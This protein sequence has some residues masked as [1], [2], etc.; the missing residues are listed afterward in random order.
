VIIRYI[1]DTFEGPALVPEDREQRAAVE[2]WIERV[3]GL[4][5]R[6]LS[7]GLMSGALAL[8]RDRLIMPR[9]LRLLRAH[10]RATPELHEVYQR[11]IEDV[12]RWI[13]VMRRPA[14][15]EAMR[16]ELVGVLSDLESALQGRE[17]VVGDA[18]SLADMMATVLAAR[19]RLMRPV[20]LD[21]YPAVA[22]H[23]ERMK[24]RPNF[25]AEDIIE[26]LDKRLMLKIM[27]PVLLPRLAALV[28]VLVLALLV[29]V[30][31]WL[32]AQLA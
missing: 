31:M 32:S 16:A 29:F 24:R 1:D 28:L 20:E 27:A 18:Y 23:Y 4:K 2:R 10:Q 30:V 21:D 6:E 26:R 14:E 19:L 13:G 11:R 7:Y 8:L 22:A 5:I 17:F 3:A 25:P 9:R 12:R 15:L